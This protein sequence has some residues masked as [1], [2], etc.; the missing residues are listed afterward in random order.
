MMDVVREAR[1]F[2]SIEAGQMYMVVAL[3]RDW[4]KETNGTLDEF[5]DY[6]DKTFPKKEDK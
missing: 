3:V 6:M 1:K 5:L 2:K 4:Q